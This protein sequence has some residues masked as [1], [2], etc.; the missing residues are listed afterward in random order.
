MTPEEVCRY[1]GSVASKFKIS[2]HFEDLV[3]EGVL[4]YYENQD[5]DTLFGRMKR[6]MH[7]YLNIKTKGISI[8]SSDIARQIAR[9]AHTE[10]TGNLATDTLEAL[11]MA[12]HGAYIEYDEHSVEDFDVEDY[13]YRKELCDIML[14]IINNHLTEREQQ[15]INLRYYH[16]MTLQEVADFL[17]LT[18]KRIHDLETKALNKMFLQLE[19]ES[20][21]VTT[22]KQ[23]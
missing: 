2:E 11:K 14:N 10:A 22:P 5:T 9:D 18:K 17:K 19:E 21:F 13:I 12:L 6:R 3:S 7:D 23:G 1:A 8:P 15:I 20:L 4:E 16:D